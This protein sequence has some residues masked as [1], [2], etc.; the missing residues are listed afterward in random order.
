MGSKSYYQPCRACGSVDLRKSRTRMW[1]RPL[2]ILL[3]RPY[4]CRHCGHR[5]FAWIRGQQ[6][7]IRHESPSL[8]ITQIPLERHATMG[9]VRVGKWIL[10]Y[11]LLACLLAAG[12]FNARSGNAL[13]IRHAFE[14]ARLFLI[15]PPKQSSDD[16][17]AHEISSTAE[18]P[19]VEVP[20]PHNEAVTTPPDSIQSAE[21]HASASREESAKGSSSAEAM[22]A[23]RPSVPAKIKSTITSDN[24]IDVRVRIDKSGR[25][26]E[27]TP[28]SASGPVA[29]SLVRYALNTARRWRFRP[30]RQ[31]GK[32][33]PSETVLEFLF[34]PSENL[35]SRVDTH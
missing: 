20:S 9:S 3:L 30:A 8:S 25:V 6:A 1:E 24:T 19:A 29:T 2:R 27:A 12:I 34:R 11:G 26:I 28:V 31:K 16:P 21:P 10:I 22:R 17:P 14:S 23:P 32:P 4:R 33:V 5:Q 7:V 18:L 35:V 13:R 15:P